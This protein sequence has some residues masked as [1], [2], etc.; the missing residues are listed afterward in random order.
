ME[1]DLSFFCEQKES[2]SGGVADFLT[3]LKSSDCEPKE[4]NSGGVADFLTQLKS[5]D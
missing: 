1:Y 4:S 5:S 2:N 3:Q